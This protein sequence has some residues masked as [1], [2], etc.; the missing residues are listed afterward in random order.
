[1]EK[2]VEYNNPSNTQD[3]TYR[4]ITKNCEDHEIVYDDSVGV[5]VNVYQVSLGHYVTEDG[6][7]DPN[8]PY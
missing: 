5:A 2:T 3:H 1:M 4:T 8:C 6:V 7:H